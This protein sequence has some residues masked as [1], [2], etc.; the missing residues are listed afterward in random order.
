MCGVNINLFILPIINSDRLLKYNSETLIKVFKCNIV[1]L[2][3]HLLHPGRILKCH[4]KMKLCFWQIE[5]GCNIL[6]IAEYVFPQSFAAFSAPVR[7][8]S[9]GSWTTRS[10]WSTTP[11]GRSSSTS[12]NPT[13]KASPWQRRTKR[14]MSGTPGA[15]PGLLVHFLQWGGAVNEGHYWQK[16]NS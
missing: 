7:T 2:Y 4:W 1:K 13:A 12:W 8:T 11:T 16:C 6:Y 5:H 14:N 15:F 3:V 10:V 9:P